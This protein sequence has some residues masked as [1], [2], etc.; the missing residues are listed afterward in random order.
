MV[1]SHHSVYGWTSAAVMTPAAQ[2]QVRGDHA[3]QHVEH[4]AQDEQPQSARGQRAE[5]LAR[6]GAQRG[7]H[8]E[9]EHRRRGRPRHVGDRLADRG[10]PGLGAT[11]VPQHVDEDHEEHREPRGEVERADP[12]ASREAGDGV[13]RELGR[14]DRR[15]IGG[16]GDPRGRR[17]AQRRGS[18]NIQ[19]WPSTSSTR[20]S[21]PGPPSSISERRCAPP[22][23][24]RAR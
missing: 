20:Y 12:L 19:R 24:A 15:G 14:T 6:R 1:P 4:V 13:D 2:A 18:R 3:T 23:S 17:S 9:R 5:G 7:A 10:R 11:P 21:R 22:A 16:P 8:E